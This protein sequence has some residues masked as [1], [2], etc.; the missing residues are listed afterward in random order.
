MLKSGAE[1]ESHTEAQRHGGK[2]R[3]KRVGL[4]VIR[5]N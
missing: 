5:E 2:K 4:C 3:G 1:E